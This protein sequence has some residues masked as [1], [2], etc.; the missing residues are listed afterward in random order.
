MVVRRLAED[1]LGFSPLGRSAQAPC[2]RGG[3]YSRASRAH[4]QRNGR[5][6]PFHLGTFSG[7]VR[8]LFLSPVPG[9]LAL[10]PP[11]LLGHCRPA[12]TLLASPSSSFLLLF[13]QPSILSSFLLSSFSLTLS[14]NLS[15]SHNEARCLSPPEGPP[16]GDERSPPAPRFGEMATPTSPS[17]V[18]RRRLRSAIAA[19][20]SPG[21]SA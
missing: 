19:A 3:R 11:Q 8:L 18:D 2:Q 16:P 5:G 7:V 15:L 9:H 21:G 1:R 4:H 14:H 13:S 17:H 20:S 6:H 12:H 10:V